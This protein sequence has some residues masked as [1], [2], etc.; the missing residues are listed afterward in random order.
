MADREMI[1]HITFA[2]L[3]EAGAV[4]TV[5]V[6]GQ[7]GGWGVMVKYGMVERPLAVRR[8]SV[9]L[10][11]RL[12]TL[13]EYLRGL[14]IVQYHVNAANYDPQT[15]T[16]STRPDSAA[17]LKRVHEAAAHDQWFREQVEQAVQE[18]DD[19]NTQWVTHEEAKT[20]WAKKRAELVERSEGNG[21]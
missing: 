21:A 4:R 6:I 19:P 5:D 3:V 13:T 9:R 17:R 1:D 2:R 16:Q 18:A 8:G 12:E 7:P 14:G 10:F 15:P 11:R 20:I